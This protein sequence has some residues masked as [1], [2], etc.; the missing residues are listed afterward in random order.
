VVSPGNLL[1]VRTGY[2]MPTDPIYPVAGYRRLHPELYG[3]DSLSLSI[4]IIIFRVKRP[5]SSWARRSHCRL[6]V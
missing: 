6:I 3:A 1:A 2:D 4:T 5:R